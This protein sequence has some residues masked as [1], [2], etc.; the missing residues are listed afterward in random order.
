[1]YQWSKLHHEYRD[2]GLKSTFGIDHAL[3]IT[4]NEHGK[5]GCNLLLFNITDAYPFHT[6]EI[7]WK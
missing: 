2:Q 6:F 4:N 7:I 5:L 3:L 1:M